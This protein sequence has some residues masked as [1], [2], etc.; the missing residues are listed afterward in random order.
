MREPSSADMSSTAFT[1]NSEI[2]PGMVVFV[3]CVVV[4]VV[5]VQ[6]S[7]RSFVLVVLLS[8]WCLACKLGRRGAEDAGMLFRS[9]ST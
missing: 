3:F 9:I 1:E 5:V 2:E 7:G 8:I 6:C 4:V